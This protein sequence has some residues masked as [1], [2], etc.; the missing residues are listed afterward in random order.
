MALLFYNY[1]CNVAMLHNIAKLKGKF[2]NYVK[3]NS[4]I[5]PNWTLYLYML[6]LYDL[7]SNHIFNLMI[8]VLAWI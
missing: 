8:L 7:Y 2:I 6:F 1:A 4:W 3:T 5:Y